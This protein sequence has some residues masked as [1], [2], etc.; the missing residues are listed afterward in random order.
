M[1]RRATLAAALAAGLPVL[2]PARAQAPADREIAPDGRLRVVG[3]VNP[4]ALRRRA[5][6]GFDGLTVDIGD[7]LASR[8]GATAQVLGMPNPGAFAAAL[9]GQEWDLAL[10]PRVTAP[11]AAHWAGDLMLLD[12]NVV[13]A[14]GVEIA[15]LEALDR[16][17]LRLAVVAG[18]PPERHFSAAL[19]QASLVQFPSVEAAIA[20]LAQRQ[21]DAYAA[22]GD[23]AARVAD[24]V[25]GA[26]V[27][28]GSNFVTTEYAAG[29]PLSRSA[30]ARSRFAELVAEVRRAELVAKAI[31]RDRVRGVRVAG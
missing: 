19:R 16:P 8:L 12:S 22:N 17:G 30:S 10:G 2:A 18:G 4:A 1:R 13:A 24:T 21:V 15:S 6:G 29:I 31:E 3:F 23:I 25:A 5:D 28:P 26:R 27:V 11:G 7:F 9:G 20:A 14:P